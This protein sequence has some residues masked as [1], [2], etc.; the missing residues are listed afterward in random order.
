MEFEWDENK[1][2]A[3]VKKHGFDFAEGCELFI[4]VGLQPFLIRADFSED[5]PEERWQGL[6]TIHGRVVAIVFME[7][8]PGLI[9]FISLR[10]ATRKERRIYEKAVQNTMGSH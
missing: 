6:G 4:N 8:Q 7:R 1:N 9:R 10:R 5:Y 2:E 3:N